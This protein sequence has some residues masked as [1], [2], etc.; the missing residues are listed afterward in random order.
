MS[1]S[2]MESTGNTRFIG[3]IEGV[4]YVD[5]VPRSSGKP[6]VSASHPALKRRTRPEGKKLVNPVFDGNTY[7]SFPRFPEEELK[8]EEDAVEGQPLQPQ[9]TQPPNPHARFSTGW[10]SGAWFS[11]VKRSTSTRGT[12]PPRTELVLKRSNTVA[13]NFEPSR[14]RQRRSSSR[15]IDEVEYKDASVENTHIPIFFP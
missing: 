3:N 15:G 11:N 7:F 12:Q 6:E 2:V 9:L 5:N 1:T 8:P 10:F 14:H 4:N 13:G